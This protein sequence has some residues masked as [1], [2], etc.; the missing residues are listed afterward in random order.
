MTTIQR[1]GF[2]FGIAGGAALGR[3]PGWSLPASAQGATPAADPFAAAVDRGLAYFRPLAAEHTR[4][5]E[6][7][8]DTIAAGDIDAARRA[9][10]ATRPSYEEIEVLAASFPETDEAIDA[11]PYAIP[12]G[13]TSPDY[14]S[15]HRIESLLFRDGDL[16]AALPFAEGFVES[17]RT[18]QGDL[19]RRQAFTAESSFAGMLALSE[20]VAS[21]KISSEEEAWSDQSLLIFFHNWRGIE[22]QYAPF[23]PLVAAADPA[24][25]TAVADAFAAAYATVAEWPPVDGVFPPYSGVP[26]AARGEI[27]RASYRLRDG[28]GE[29]MVA[30]GLD[31]DLG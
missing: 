7:L 16:A 28:L 31:L 12:G 22:S 14:V 21:K 20:E 29:A 25:A 24:L 11:R 18:L 2:L 15:V 19:E 23:A 26:I 9:Y 17:A 5:A 10:I 27:V 30:L 3:L 6:A 1:R 13:E 4:S 8:R